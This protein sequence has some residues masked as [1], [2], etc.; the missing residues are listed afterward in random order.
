MRTFLRSLHFT[1]L[2]KFLKSRR[3]TRSLCRMSAHPYVP[4]FCTHIHT[5][6]HVHAHALNTVLYTRHAMH[7]SLG[8]P[9]PV[10]ERKKRKKIRLPTVLPQRPYPFG[11]LFLSLTRS[12]A[13]MYSSCSQVSRAASAPDW[14]EQPRITSTVQPCLRRSFS[15][16][17]AAAGCRSK[18][19]R[20]TT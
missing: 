9:S 15:H 20:K 6:A 18:Q 4:Y 14:L 8:L 10:E 11:R 12:S 3:P 16:R 1:I 5:L 2:L 19:T 7:T 17:N 13:C